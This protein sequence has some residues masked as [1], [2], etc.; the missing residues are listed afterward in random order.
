[1]LLKL[2]LPAFFLFT[3]CLLVAL[4]NQ[5]IQ[6][7]EVILALLLVLGDQGFSFGTLNLKLLNQPLVLFLHDLQLGLLALQLFLL[8][9]KLFLLLSERVAL[10]LRFQH[11]F[12]D[13]FHELLIMMRKTF[14]RLG[15]QGEIVQA[16]G[17]QQ[18]LQR[19]QVTAGGVQRLQA[20]LELL[21]RTVIFCIG[22]FDLRFKLLDACIQL[23]DVLAGKI[24]ALLIG[25]DLLLQRS[26]IRLC[27]RRFRTQRIE[28]CAQLCSS[29]LIGFLLRLHLADLRV[30]L[31][32]RRR[33]DIA[34]QEQGQRQGT[35]KNTYISSL[36]SKTPS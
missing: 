32:R 23:V 28:L 3:R 35:C 2:R 12:L 13:F 4:R 17:I 21:H 7:G 18:N 19:R 14:H 11:V 33:K 15:A 5:G 26:L 30:V 6:L 36:H 22:L 29:G 16:R 10:I 25:F 8:L 24:N 31:G 27:V 1:M 20:D 9:R 34:G